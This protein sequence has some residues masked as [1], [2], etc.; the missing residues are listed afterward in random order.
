[1]KVKRPAMNKRLLLRSTILILAHQHISTSC[2]IKI[3][4]ALICRIFVPKVIPPSFPDS[5]GIN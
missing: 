1:M 3:G 5:S 4:T 2:E